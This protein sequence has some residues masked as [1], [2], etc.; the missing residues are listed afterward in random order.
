MD[1]LLALI[2]H[3]QYGLVHQVR[4]HLELA[5]LVLLLE[6]REEVALL[7]DHLHQDFLLLL[8]LGHLRLV[9]LLL[10][11]DYGIGQLDGPSRHWRGV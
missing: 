6:Q 1:K 8:E 7:L 4:C 5:L 3:V 2:A 9:T 11:V 10:R